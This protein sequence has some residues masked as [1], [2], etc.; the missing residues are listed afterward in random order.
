MHWSSLLRRGKEVLNA[1]KPIVPTLVTSH[2]Q[3]F[4]SYLL[5]FLISGV[6]DIVTICLTESPWMF[7]SNAF[8]N[9]DKHYDCEGQSNGGW[10]LPGR[11]YLQGNIA[12][13]NS[14]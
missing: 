7:G 14:L 5:I 4:Y 1:A 12:V 3:V 8:S 2:F 6:F 10:W 9:S 11:G 13:M